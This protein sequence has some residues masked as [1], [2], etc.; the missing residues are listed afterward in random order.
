MAFVAGKPAPIFHNLNA[1]DGFHFLAIPLNPAVTANY[2]PT[3]LTAADYP[4]VVPQDQ[5]VDTVA[6]GAVLV[7]VL[8]GG[9]EGKAGMVKIKNMTSGEEVLVARSE[10]GEKIGP[11]VQRRH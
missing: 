5:A 8:V 4:G 2:V 9:E 7:A 10:I 11:M 6:V 3:R 1:A